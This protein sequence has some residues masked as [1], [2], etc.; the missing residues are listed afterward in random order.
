M[1]ETVGSPYYIAPEVL[2]GDYNEKCDVWSIGVILY[3]MLVGRPPFDGNNELEVVRA[4]K[5]GIIDWNSQLLDHISDEAKDL[6]QQ[7]LTIDQEKRVSAERAMQHSWIRKYDNSSKDLTVII[8]C[9]QSL[10]RF[11]T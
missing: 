7:L 1:K 5:N 9:L 4:V 8:R 10:Q 11:R 2:T 6:M 3:M